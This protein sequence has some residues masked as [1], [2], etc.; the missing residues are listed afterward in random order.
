MI[1]LINRKIVFNYKKRKWLV[2]ILKK[3]NVF[4]LI[5]YNSIFKYQKLFEFAF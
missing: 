5:I 3:M 1:F 2:V 4:L